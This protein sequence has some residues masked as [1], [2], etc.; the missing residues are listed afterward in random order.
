MVDNQYTSIINSQVCIE[1]RTILYLWSVSLARLATCRG[2]P[3]P[4]NIWKYIQ[5]PQRKGHD[6]PTTWESNPGPS[7]MRLQFRVY[8]I[9][10]VNLSTIFSET[11]YLNTK[12]LPFAFHTYIGQI[13]TTILLINNTLF[14][15]HDNFLI[16]L[17]KLQIDKGISNNMYLN[18]LC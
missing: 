15:K 1:S 4:D 8:R 17:G 7:A 3:K 11:H 5:T 6:Y 14:L 10:D 9:T 13:T 12:K 16:C 2:K 18:K